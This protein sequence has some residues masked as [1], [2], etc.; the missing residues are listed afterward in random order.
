MVEK[1]IPINDTNVELIT[2]FLQNAGRSTETF[3]YYQNRPLD[4]VRNHLYTCV[5]SVGDLII[6]YGHLD[7]E[8]KNVWLGVAVSDYFIGKGIGKK[9]MYHLIEKAK[10]L[11]IAEVRLSVDS[12]NLKAKR[13]YEKF[14]F[15][16]SEVKG[17]IEFYKRKL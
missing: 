17:S 10:E 16:R 7:E 12:K 14:N 13:L 4:V 8:G 9:I 1:L 6:G 3:R 5:Y 15:L 2:T 11:K